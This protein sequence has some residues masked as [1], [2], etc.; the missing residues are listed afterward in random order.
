M[1]STVP[2]SYNTSASLRDKYLTAGKRTE[3]PEFDWKSSE[4]QTPLIGT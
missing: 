3:T 4:F 2:E 1:G